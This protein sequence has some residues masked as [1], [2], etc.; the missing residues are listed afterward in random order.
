MGLGNDRLGSRTAR[1]DWPG[2]RARSCVGRDR[3]VC[4]ARGNKLN[5]GPGDVSVIDVRVV[6]R[7]EPATDGEARERLLRGLRRELAELEIEGMRSVLDG[8]AP[9]GA[10]AA[11]PVTIGAIVVAMSASGGVLPAVVATIR[12]W[13]GR[14]AD[15]HR[16]AVTIDGDT[17]ELANAS[18][19]Q[20]Q[21]LV[22]A[23]V[24]RHTTGG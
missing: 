4:H 15:R 14:H 21:E 19:E 5:K 7:T 2:V 24:R 23:F 1:V 22:E 18:T 6:L 11:D 20:R 13:L 10:K 12:D 16:I 8:S 3:G 9:T 17:I